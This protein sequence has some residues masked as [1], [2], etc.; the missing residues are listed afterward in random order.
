[1]QLYFPSRCKSATT[2]VFGL[3]SKENDFEA[4]TLNG[5]MNAQCLSMFIDDFAAGIKQPTVLVL[6]NAPFHHSDQIKKKIS[7]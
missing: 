7:S 1:M 5:S 4:Y 3:L 2:N 6:D